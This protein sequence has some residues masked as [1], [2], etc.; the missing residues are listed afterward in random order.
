LLEET[1]SDMNNDGKPKTFCQDLD[2]PSDLAFLP[3][4]GV[5]TSVIS[6]KIE[7]DDLHM[8]NKVSINCSTPLGPYKRDIPVP[9]VDIKDCKLFSCQNNCSFHGD[10]TNVGV[11]N[12]SKN[13]YGPDCSMYFENNC[14]QSSYWPQSCWKAS[15]SDCHHIDYNVDSTSAPIELKNGVLEDVRS[16]P[17]VQCQKIGTGSCQMCV[18]LE[19]IKVNGNELQGCPT[20]KLICRDIEV[21][22]EK[23]PCITIAK[24]PRLVCGYVPPSESTTNNPNQPENQTNNSTQII[25]FALVGGLGLILIAVATYFVVKRFLLKK[26]NSEFVRVNTDNE[27]L[28]PLHVDSDDD[29]SE[30]ESVLN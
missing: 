23:M 18:D 20:T 25:I 26:D 10:C 7:G 3:K 29:V 12:C 13:F 27:D 6:L 5:C 15:F 14:I 8:C 24:D 2:I 1:Q 30:D 16:L 9:C 28:Q 17:L 21:S 19:D 11:C 4:C 22:K